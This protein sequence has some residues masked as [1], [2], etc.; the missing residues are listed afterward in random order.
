MKITESQL[1]L[2]RSLKCERLSSNTANFS[3][4]NDFY[5]TRNN[6]LVDTLQ[7][8]AYDD[9]ENNRIAYYIVKTVDDKI[10]FFFSLKYGLLYDEFIEGDRLKE[11]KSFYDTIL[12]MSLDE[13]QPVENKKAIASIL[14]S[15]RS[16]KGIKKED[17]ARVLHL[18]VDSDE[19]SKIFG[20][21]LKN[22]GRTFPGVELVHFCANDAH[23]E[24]W[25]E[26]DLPQNM[27]TTIFWYFIVPKILEMLKIV[28][29]E[30]VFLF[31]ADLTPYEEL[32]RYYS[33]Q[34]KFEKVDEHCVAI[35]MYDFTCQF[36]SQK[37]CELEG[38]RKQFF[39][40]FNN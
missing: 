4:I 15:V 30:Y 24:E 9:D 23:R 38:K 34:L 26:Y 31:A 36:M 17:V 3:L 27:G 5:N 29:C 8:D 6:S 25:D 28:G 7:G 2:L 21:N 12:R 18:S 16:K 13:A 10:L 33:D 20:K 37:T 1:E 19:F 39:E 40:E 32:I 11:I 22:V 14:E 35:P